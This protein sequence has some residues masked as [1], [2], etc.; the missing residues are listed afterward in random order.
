MF[1]RY[2]TKIDRLINAAVNSSGDTSTSL[3]RKIID[4]GK[5]RLTD[6][7]GSIEELPAEWARFADKMASNS[8]GITDHDIDVLHNAGHS[9]DA[10]LEVMEC[11]A[12][13]EGI[14]RL[15]VVRAALESE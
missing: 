6:P 1:E 4:R 13:A 12:L 9:D 8:T 11:A 7:H 2:Q 3:R 15:E 10:I 5:G 14:G